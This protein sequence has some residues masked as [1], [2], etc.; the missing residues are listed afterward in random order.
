MKRARVVERRNPRAIV[1]SPGGKVVNPC[2]DYQSLV[3]DVGGARRA[4]VSAYFFGRQDCK[5]T[6][7]NGRNNLLI[8][9]RPSHLV[10]EC[11]EK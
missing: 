7:V 1:V 4:K 10:P 3:G 2:R 6:C 9:L 11:R 8:D 5:D